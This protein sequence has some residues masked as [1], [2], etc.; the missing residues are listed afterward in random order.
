MTLEQGD[1]VLTNSFA[2]FGIAYSEPG[3][4]SQAQHSELAFVLIV[5]HLVCR[6]ANVD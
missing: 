3:L 2:L 1:F 4:G 5:M 6:F